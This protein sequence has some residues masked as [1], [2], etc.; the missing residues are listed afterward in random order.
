MTPQTPFRIERDS[1]GQLFVPAD[2]YYGVQTARAVRNFPIS[3]IRPHAVYV[4]AAAAVKRAAAEANVELRVLNRRTGKA[5]ARAAAEVMDGRLADQFVVDV[6]NSGACTAFHMNVN[7]VLANRAIELL[8][9]ERGDY[10]R[11]HPNDHVNMAQSSNDV[12]PTVTRLAALSL[13]ERLLPEL[14]SLDKALRAKAREFD[15]VVK[16]GRTHLQD[17]V[18]MRLGQEFSG[19]AGAVRSGRGRIQH[20]ARALR[21]IGL[22]ATAVGTGINAHPD[23]RVKVVER[24]KALTGWELRPAENVFET[25][26]SFAAFAELSSALKVLALELIRIANDLRLLSSGPNTGL[27]EINLPAVMPGSSIMPGKVNPSLPEMLDMVCF[28]VVGNDTTISLAVQA[29]QMEINVMT[30]VVGYDLLQSLDLLRN[31]VHVFTE[32]CVRGI[33]ANVERCQANAE[34]TL[35]LATALNPHIGYEKA[36]EVAQEALATGR[37][38]KEIVVEKKLLSKAEADRVLDVRA[39]AGPSIRRKRA[40]RRKA[41]GGIS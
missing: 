22:G 7:E 31:G 28:Q 34:R 16:A 1:L 9:G 24:L 13:V 35:A 33:T 21:E 2:A 25:H 36:V 30:P 40:S 11:V 23:F 41:A 26:Q 17:A 19:Y 3:G 32:R 27:F 18:P 5:I 4:W 15:S 14:A 8:G 12:M 29:G 38:L 10:T 6:F 20:A 37:G 39:L